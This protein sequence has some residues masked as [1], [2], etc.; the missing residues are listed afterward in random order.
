[1]EVYIV[2]D[3]MDEQIVSVHRTIIGANK[4][5][6]SYLEKEDRSGEGDYWVEVKDFTLED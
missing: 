6:I 2:Y 4:S 3:G 5:V 1:M